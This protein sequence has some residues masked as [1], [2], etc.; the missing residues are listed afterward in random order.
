MKLNHPTTV[1]AAGGLLLLGSQMSEAG[2]L[3]NPSPSEMEQLVECIQSK[4]KKGHLEVMQQSRRDQA[5]SF[6]WELEQ[7]GIKLNATLQSRTEA[8][9]SQNVFKVGDADLDGK[10]DL[11]PKQKEPTPE[12]QSLFNRAV[13]ESLKV[14]KTPQKRESRVCPGLWTLDKNEIGELAEGTVQKIVALTYEDGQIACT[15]AVLEG[16]RVL[17]AEH[18]IEEGAKP[19]V[20]IP[21]DP[22]AYQVKVVHATVTSTNE[23]LDLA[24]LQLP[25]GSTTHAFNLAKEESTE[26]MSYMIGHGNQ[27]GWVIS[28]F[29]QP[30][31]TGDA[32]FDARSRT[33]SYPPAL[34]VDPGASGGPQMNEAGE[35]TGVFKHFAPDPDFKW[36]SV[37]T[38]IDAVHGFLKRAEKSEVKF[39]ENESKT[40]VVGHVASEAILKPKGRY[41]PMQYIIDEFC[42]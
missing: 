39:P 32:L 15:G 35:L 1:A 6:E 29:P 26:E 34:C 9:L 18:C 16:D 37:F 12:E 36:S 2:K 38:P 21:L 17:T 30:N 41:M 27:Y 10:L 23:T 11:V 3:K 7:K 14:C 8:G 5:E 13:N 28:T 42:E 19:R 22:A 4:S 33:F 31:R 40:C 24:L 20:A 25:K